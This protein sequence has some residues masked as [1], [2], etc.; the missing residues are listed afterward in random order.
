MTVLDGLEDDEIE[1]A[2]AGIFNHF[3]VPLL[4]SFG[5]KRFLAL[6]P[7]V[8]AQI[9]AYI[10]GY[11]ADITRFFKGILRSTVTCLECNQQSSISDPFLDISVPIGASAKGK[12]SGLFGW[13][14]RGTARKRLSKAERKRQKAARKAQKR[15]L[16]K[17][18]GKGHSRDPSVG[19]AAS[20]GSVDSELSAIEANGGGA[21]AAAAAAA[22]SSSWTPRAPGRRLR[23]ATLPCR[24]ESRFDQRSDWRFLRAVVLRDDA[25]P[26]RPRRRRRPRPVRHRGTGLYL[27]VAVRPHLQAW[28]FWDVPI[29]SVVPVG[30]G[31]GCL[32]VPLEPRRGH[33]CHAR[34]V[35]R[36]PNCKHLSPEAPTTAVAAARRQHRRLLRPH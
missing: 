35:W 33:R 32:H 20:F 6:D 19:S 7:M 23:K 26:S 22:A 9:K 15:E 11:Q 27:A 8:Q 30:P 1:L 16:K 31:C 12:R 14:S 29:G 17:K 36:T 4:R 34:R 10:H 24:R 2:R 21:A 3:G 18:R 25:L 13:S 28:R 5:D